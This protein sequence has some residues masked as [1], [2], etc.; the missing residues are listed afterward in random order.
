MAK[1]RNNNPENP[2][3]PKNGLIW[4]V[5]GKLQPQLLLIKKKEKK[6][7]TVSESSEITT[8]TDRS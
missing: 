2:E 8:P 4:A 5:V 6:T 7:Q 3:F 1:N